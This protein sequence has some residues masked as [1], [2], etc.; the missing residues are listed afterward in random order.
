MGDNRTYGIDLLKILSMFM[1][2]ILHILGCG[3]VLVSANKYSVAY[4][5]YW[6]IEALAY[7]GVDVFAIISG[8]LLI[9][10]KIKIRKIWNLWTTVFF[11][12]FII[13]VLFYIYS[14]FNKVDF[15]GIRDLIYAVCFPVI[16][17]QYWY[18]SC[19]FSMY[20][21]LPFINKGLTSLTQEEYKKLCFTII[22]LFS[23]CP[24]IAMKRYDSFNLNYGYSTLWLISC[25]IISGYA[26]RFNLDFSNR[27]CIF[28]FA[29]S[30]F[31][32]WFFKFISHFILLFVFK[33]NTEIDVLLIILR[34]L[35]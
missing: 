4:Y 27:K 13:N 8:Y 18:F 10:K 2:V 1:I 35:C 11:Y 25:Y 20:L 26:R 21:F 5:S 17:R 24:I 15:I 22:I 34:F 28:I 30:V 16:S 33:I 12:C 7:C 23:L 31:F 19:Y 14:Y 3:G 29:L 6:F 32:A 9:N